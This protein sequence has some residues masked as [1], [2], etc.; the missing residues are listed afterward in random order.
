MAISSQGITPA[1]VGRVVRSTA[2]T[3]TV[4]DTVIAQPHHIT[5]ES[6][7]AALPATTEIGAH[8]RT[9]PARHKAALPATKPEPPAAATWLGSMPSTDDTARHGSTATLSPA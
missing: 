7:K 3:K 9:S 8:Q 2:T 6:R 5:P 4:K 1:R